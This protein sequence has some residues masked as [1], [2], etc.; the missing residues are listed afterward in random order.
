MPIDRSYFS[1]PA[2]NETNTSNASAVGGTAKLS[3]GF[4]FNGQPKAQFSIPAQ[5]RMLD[6]TNLYL[7][8]QMVVCDKDGVTLSDES[9]LGV[10]NGADLSQAGN[11]NLSNWGGVQ[12]CIQKVEIQSKKSPVE[13][14]GVNNYAMY[15]NVQAGHTNNGED[16][17]RTPLIRDLAAG[18]HADQV[19]RHSVLQPNATNTTSGDMPNLVN[20]LDQNFGQFFGMKLNVSLLSGFQ[21]L[22]LDNTALGGLIITLHLANSNAVFYRRFRDQGTGQAAASVDGF[23]YRLKNLRL[24]G[25]Y[26]TPTDDEIKNMNLQVNLNARVNNIDSIVSSNSITSLTPQLSQ[27]KSFINLFLDDDQ[28]NSINFNQ[29]SFRQ[30][31]ALSSYTNNKN[32]VRSPQDYKV[33]VK[34]NFSRPRDEDGVAYSPAD[35]LVK[36][37]GEG[38]SEVLANFERS[39]LDGALAA[40]TSADVDLQEG[41]IEQDFEER[42]ATAQTEGVGNN[43][44]ANLLGIGLDYTLG[45]GATTNY[46]N[47]DYSLRIESEVAAGNTQLPSSRRDKFEI[48]E[49]Y[50]RNNEVL[51]SKS[52][53]KVM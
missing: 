27:V 47:Q 53:V 2:I 30:P 48:L 32:N 37:A 31:L 38:N 49:S 39:I 29:S 7:T 23:F 1:I 10:K 11:L 8:G 9:N 45:M 26:L 18:K 14:I 42:G 22:Y 40:H 52:L 33:E 15:Q 28:Q 51:D 24:E 6:I 25:Y 4:L 3:G 43:T 5:N 46:V 13:L 36:T 41:S 17:L 44:R 34:P 50:A 19:N 20:Q 35:L 12:N 16:Y 21:R